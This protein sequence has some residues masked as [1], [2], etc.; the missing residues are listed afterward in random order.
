MAPWSWITGEDDNIEHRR[1]IASGAYGEVHEVAYPDLNAN[2]GMLFNTA[3]REV[4]SSCCLLMGR[5]LPGRYYILSAPKIST[6]SLRPS[7]NCP[8]VAPRGILLRF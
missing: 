2:L 8:L 7:I 3:T 1:R 6:M 5:F 4:A